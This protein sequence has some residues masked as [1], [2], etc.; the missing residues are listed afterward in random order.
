MKKFFILLAI[1]ALMAISGMAANETPSRTNS[2]EVKA[3]RYALADINL[4]YGPTVGDSIMMVIPE[5]TPVT[6]DD[7]CDCEW[8]PVEYE[9]QIGF[10]S[11]ENLSRPA[12]EVASESNVAS[13]TQSGY[14]PTKHRTYRKN[15]KRRGYSPKRSS[16]HRRKA[17]RGHNYRGH[18]HVRYYTN[19]HGHRVQSPTYYRKA[20]K[21]ATA[22][23]NDGTYS[24]SQNRRGTCSHHGGV[25]RWL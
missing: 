6:I 8:I 13:S 3:T 1:N 4:H 25:R 5:G 15:T 16:T 12:V 19:V 9:G 10:I 11:T 23:C 24:F 21:G 7:D 18:G 22:L 20:P 2:K 14:A 17:Y